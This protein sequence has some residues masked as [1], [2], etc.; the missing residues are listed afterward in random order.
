M[1]KLEFFIREINKGAW[2]FDYKFY[3]NNHVID[4]GTY[5]YRP[6]KMPENLNAVRNTGRWAVRTHL[7][8]RYGV[9]EMTTVCLNPKSDF[10]TRGELRAKAM[11]KKFMEK[12]D[13]V[14]TEEKAQEETVLMAEPQKIEKF[15]PVKG[16]RLYEVVEVGGVWT[17]KKHDTKWFTAE[18]AKTQL[19]AKVVN[20]D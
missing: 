15:T 8:K 17:I 6:W 1:Y 16:G 4:E 2:A 13:L 19:F 3:Q 12:Y 10:V 5:T 11:R 7:A 18:E 14:S 20:G 9:R